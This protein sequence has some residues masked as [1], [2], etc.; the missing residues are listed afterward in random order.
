MTMNKVS[1]A[2]MLA[3]LLITSSSAFALECA[4]DMYQLVVSPGYSKLNAQLAPADMAAFSTAMTPISN[5]A[6]ATDAQ[7]QVLADLAAA[8][9]VAANTALAVTSARVVVT[10]PDGTVALD[11]GKSTNS[12]AN[13]KAKAINENHNTRL[14]ILDA[15]LFPCGFGLE[16]KVSTSVGGV[17]VAIAKRI[18]AYMNSLGTV[19]VSYTK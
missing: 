5:F 11:T 14:A 4:P 3:G 15:Q 6:A 9:V 17:E 12:L 2:L 16:T 8:K 18:G 7:Y 19:R 13:F 1:R 10:L